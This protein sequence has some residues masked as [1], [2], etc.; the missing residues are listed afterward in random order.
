MEVFNIKCI[1]LIVFV[2]IGLS[3]AATVSNE[4]FSESKSSMKAKCEN[5]YNL[6]CLKLD[7][8]SLIDR[9]SAS[10]SE[11]QLTSGISLVREND[12]NK[13]QN[14]KIVAE[15]ARAFPD[16]P[17]KR[18][19]GFLVAK[20]Q[21]LLQSFALRFK[22]LNDDVI[23]EVESRK[24]GGGGFGD[25]KGGYGMIA[26]M[27]MMKGAMGAMAMGAVAALAGKAL[28][29]GMMALTMAAMVAL[30]SLTS[31][32][33]KKTTYEIISKPVYS[34]SH[35]YSSSHGHGHGGGSDEHSAYGGSYKRSFQDFP[36]PESVVKA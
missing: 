26:M 9:I 22:L 20:I 4:I 30:K 33:D 8:L 13:T 15:L 10:N 16:S 1:F 25:K 18:L 7:I 14:S 3:S 19:N 32:G 28:M 21:E 5:S 29:T 12:V 36:L 31:K 35:S 6:M 27:M 23:S 2:T 34:H 11:Y 24:G 17:E